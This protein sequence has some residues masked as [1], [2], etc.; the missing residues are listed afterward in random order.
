MAAGRGP[1]RYGRARWRLAEDSDLLR[2]SSPWA[3]A[4]VALA[5]DRTER[6]NAPGSPQAP[7]RVNPDTHET[8]Q[9]L[10]E[11]AG[12]RAEAAGGQ[13]GGIGLQ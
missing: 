5:A 8:R 2:A 11:V 1:S 10:T 3:K 7:R 12:S 9:Q 6:T 13:V 4:D